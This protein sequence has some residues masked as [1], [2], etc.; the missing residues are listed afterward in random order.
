[1]AN[2]TPPC[3]VTEFPPPGQHWQ[4]CGNASGYTK[5]T[6][7]PTSLSHS[8]ALYSL[9]SALPFMCRFM[10][11]SGDGVSPTARSLLCT[12]FS[13]LSTLYSLRFLVPYG[14]WRDVRSGTIKLRLVALRTLHLNLTST[15]VCRRQA[16][17]RQMHPP[18][19]KRELAK[20]THIPNRKA[21]SHSR[22]VTSK[23]SK[24]PRR[25]VC[26]SS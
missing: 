10:P 1:M 5:A 12:L 2:R 15:S 24:L 9:L 17:L 4:A 18:K 22:T 21:R 20:A 7:S 3:Y 19:P 25:S 8:L 14:D 23:C 16:S 11:T 26:F 6:L 13:L